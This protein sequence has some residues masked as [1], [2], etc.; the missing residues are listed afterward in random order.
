MTI[1]KHLS[2]CRTIG[3]A[4]SEIRL[5]FAAPNIHVVSDISKHALACHGD[6][7]INWQVNKR[8]SYICGQTIYGDALLAN[9]GY[10]RRDSKLQTE[11]VNLCT[12]YRYSFVEY[13]TTTALL[14][15]I[16]LC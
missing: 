11:D 16:S 14:N 1:L 3:K 10:T 15:T 7:D 6:G 13:F 8:A 12:Y 2:H 4:S 5:Y 9:I